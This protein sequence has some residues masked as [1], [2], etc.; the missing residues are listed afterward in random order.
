MTTGNAAQM[1]YRAPGPAGRSH[2]VPTPNFRSVEGEA[3]KDP[4]T[5]GV[6]W[7]GG[8][9]GGA[10]VEGSKREPCTLAVSFELAD[11]YSFPCRCPSRKRKSGTALHQHIRPTPTRRCRG[12][13][14]DENDEWG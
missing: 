11:N 5:P 4:V 2:N 3:A 10:R 6:T 13:L 7:I 12:R 14:G 8:A 1:P 9:Q